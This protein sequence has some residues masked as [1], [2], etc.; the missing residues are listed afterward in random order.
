MP[1]RL[2]PEMISRESLLRNRWGPSQSLE[3]FEATALDWLVTMDL[4]S[5]QRRELLS[6]LERPDHEGLVELVVSDLAAS[7]SR[8]FGSHGIHRKLLISQLVELSLI[9]I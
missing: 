1:S 6:R 4:S 3:R 8:G 7:G 2:N 9:H 5:D